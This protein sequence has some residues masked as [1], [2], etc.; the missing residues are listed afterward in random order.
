MALPAQ[1]FGPLLPPGLLQETVQGMALPARML[2]PQLPPALLQDMV[3]M[4]VLPGLKLG[5]LVALR[6]LS[7]SL[8]TVSR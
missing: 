8:Q 1:R 4:M 2:G 7:L 6:V 3:G 5:L